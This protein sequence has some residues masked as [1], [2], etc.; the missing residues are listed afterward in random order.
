MIYNSRIYSCNRSSTKSNYV[1]TYNRYVRKGFGKKKITD[2]KY[3]D[4]LFF[5]NALLKEG[6][7]GIDNRNGSWPAA[8]DI[9][10]GGDGQHHKD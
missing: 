4:V 8:S 9:S 10:D 6:L 2:I 5:Y 3:S 7:I 1:F